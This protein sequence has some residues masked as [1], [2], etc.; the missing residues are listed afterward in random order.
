[1]INKE[2]I[3]LGWEEHFLFIIVFLCYFLP[4]FDCLKV[5]LI[6]AHNSDIFDFVPG[7][8]WDEIREF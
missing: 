8:S 1:M 7:T 6:I 3:A 4:G 2:N 5:F